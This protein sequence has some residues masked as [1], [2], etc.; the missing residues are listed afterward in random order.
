MSGLR[1]AYAL[2]LPSERAD[3]RRQIKR[4]EGCPTKTEAPCRLPNSPTTPPRW[5]PPTTAWPPTRPPG[6]HPTAPPDPRERW[7]GY[8]L[9]HGKCPECLTCPEGELCPPTDDPRITFYSEGGFNGSTRSFPLRLPPEST[10]PV[11]QT[12]GGTLCQDTTSP[13]GS[14]TKSTAIG[15]EPRSAFIDGNYSLH[16][17]AKGG[18]DMSSATKCGQES[19]TL[20][21]CGSRGKC[22]F[23]REM[24]DFQRKIGLRDLEGGLYLQHCTHFGPTTPPPFA[25]GGD[26]DNGVDGA[27]SAGVTRP[28]I[29]ISD[30]R[31]KAVV[32][33]YPKFPSALDLPADGD[34]YSWRNF[35]KACDVYNA[36]RKS[37]YFLAES[38]SDLQAR[39]LSAFFAIAKVRTQGY[40]VCRTPPDNN[41][42]VSNLQKH[43][44]HDAKCSY[45][46]ILTQTGL[47][48]HSDDG[49]H[50]ASQN[51]YF[52]RAAMPI[53]WPEGYS[54]VDVDLHDLGDPDITTPR[55]C[56]NPDSVCGDGVTAWLA[57]ISYWNQTVGQIT[58]QTQDTDIWNNPRLGLLVEDIPRVSDVH[59]QQRKL[60]GLDSPG[61]TPG[62]TPGMM[63]LAQGLPTPGLVNPA[64]PTP[65]SSAS[66]PVSTP[67]PLPKPDPTLAVILDAYPQ[68]PT[69]LKLPP[70]GSN[71]CRVREVPCD[72]FY[73][74]RH[75]LEAVHIYNSMMDPRFLGSP[76]LLTNTRFLLAFF[77]VADTVTH[78]FRVCKEYLNSQN[79]DLD[80]GCPDVAGGQCGSANYLTYASDKPTCSFGPAVTSCTDA[81]GD[82][83]DGRYCYYGRGA[84][85][86]HFPEAYTRVDDHLQGLLYHGKPIR[87]CEN[88]DLVCTDG[89]LAWLVSI[90]YCM[91]LCDAAT[92]PHECLLGKVAAVSQ[93]D[94][95]R[96]TYRNYCGALGIPIPQSP[97]PSR[98]PTP[99]P[100]VP[101]RPALDPVLVAV[102][103]R[104]PDKVP[105]VFGLQEDGENQCRVR[106][107]PCQGFYTWDLFSKA[108]TYYNYDSEKEQRPDSFLD[109]TATPEQ[110]AESLCRFFAVAHEMTH[111]Y[112]TC[113]QPMASQGEDNTVGCPDTGSEYCEYNVNYTTHDEPGGQCFNKADP[114]KTCVD[115]WGN[116]LPGRYCYYQRGPLPF[117]W[118]GA[119]AV[120]DGQLVGNTLPN[121]P[122]SYCQD[123]DATCRDGASAWMAGIAY[124]SYHCRRTADFR[125][126][127]LKGFVDPS[128]AARILNQYMV[129]MKA[130]G[131][132]YSSCADVP[133]GFC[134]T[135][136]TSATCTN[137]D[138]SEGK[139]NNCDCNEEESACEPGG[140]HVILCDQADYPVPTEKPLPTKPA[141]SLP[142]VGPT[143][144]PTT[145]KATPAV[146]YQ[147]CGWTTN[148]KGPVCMN[149][150]KPVL[151]KPSG[152]DFSGSVGPPCPNPNVPGGNEIGCPNCF[153][154]KDEAECNSG[155]FVTT[156]G[157]PAPAEPT[158]AAVPQEPPPSPL[159]QPGPPWCGNF[160]GAEWYD[161]QPLTRGPR[162]FPSYVCDPN[163]KECY[164]Q[165]TN[166]MYVWGGDKCKP[167][168]SSRVECSCP[169]NATSCSASAMSCQV[170]NT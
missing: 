117:Y 99:K 108:V 105:Q 54:L 129:Y 22:D 28:P 39:A 35:V 114:V 130:L 116:N 44:G 138:G 77:A 68:L 91:S 162:G 78:Q 81:W 155:Y 109:H 40:T 156:S 43:A 11:F 167:P 73:T 9:Q 21:D 168:G 115:A 33:T 94:A 125:S 12:T 18:E 88:P 97:K 66:T 30:P 84:H 1:D 147:K 49:T 63:D 55:F 127:I 79:P 140:N 23:Y 46:S 121:I 6:P 37:A 133:C 59:I 10:Q 74:W 16:L 100:T 17:H 58:S 41:S 61:G 32:E 102:Q 65:P 80:H 142:T 104:F 144:A 159:K 3:L 146:C 160:N 107:W 25:E 2:L 71:T 154:G 112:R 75:F 98:F 56:A 45:G 136:C 103:K 52:A 51:C 128:Q 96:D 141:Y 135:G 101:S 161:P 152:K 145:P 131:L 20:C 165:T 153:R 92:V 24:D 124:W 122:A 82:T 158:K 151:E 111:G 164:D 86:L 5:P 50:I 123:P 93:I 13:W 85:P 110:N 72:G 166:Y 132:C 64:R 90:A 26:L 53:R 143:T 69:V 87:I 119:Y 62:G 38:S 42:T 134:T 83:L 76:D 4:H 157:C 34:F 31:L 60:L 163:S 15:F 148:D 150:G 139:R 106:D 27:G 36:R 67:A 70:D 95:S 170:V 47:G 118:A 14:E 149:S 137:R 19:V 126:S 48:C 57:S 113:K 7:G 120:T 29:V 169:G 89:V 8:W